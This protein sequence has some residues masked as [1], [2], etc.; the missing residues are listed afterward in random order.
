MP[1]GRV[2][3]QSSGAERQS[4]TVKRT[5]THVSYCINAG[6]GLQNRA[7]RDEAGLACDVR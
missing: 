4:D 7:R 5:N 1:S 3:R 6:D 2:G